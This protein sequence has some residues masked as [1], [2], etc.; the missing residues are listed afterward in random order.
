MVCRVWQVPMETTQSSFF[1]LVAFCAF[2]SCVPKAEAACEVNTSII[3]F[4]E[5]VPPGTVIMKIPR[6][7]GEQWAFREDGPRGFIELRAS[8]HQVV[9]YFARE[10]DLEYLNELT[11][12]TRESLPF[13]LECSYDGWKHVFKQEIVLIDVNDNDPEF[14]PEL[15]AT[16]TVN[17]NTSPGTSILHLRG[18]AR[19]RDITGV[20]NSYNISRHVDAENDGYEYFGVTGNGNELMLRQPVDFDFL[21][22]MDRSSY[23]LNL[24]AIVS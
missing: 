21:R 15:P 13:T 14:D 2:F 20:V 17:E 12:L 23:V 9:F 18:Y 6:V 5:D 24:T 3:S 16:V 8:Q 10:P 7:S 22:L 1:F 4:R 11:T 19:D